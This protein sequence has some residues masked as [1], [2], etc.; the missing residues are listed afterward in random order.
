[1]DESTGMSW[2]TPVLYEG[3]KTNPTIDSTY[4]LIS[5][6]ENEHIPFPIKR[7][8]W[9]Y[10]ND[11]MIRGKHAH[12]KCRQVMYCVKGKVIARLYQVNEQN[13]I[14]K[15]AKITLTEQSLGLLIEL[16]TFIDYTT[17]DSKEAIVV[18]LASEPYDP[19]DI[20]EYRS[21]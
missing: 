18:V 10:L 12:R 8:F 15:E 4:D 3:H 7:V 14:A 11:L 20:I 21:S 6:T 19:E 16:F 1:M 17:V 13:R 2:I 5:V 9:V